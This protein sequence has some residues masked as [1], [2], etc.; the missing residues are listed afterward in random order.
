M[1]QRKIIKLATNTLVVSLPS[2]WAKQHGIK[3]GDAVEITE[4]PHKLTIATQQSAQKKSTL[5]LGAPSL[6]GRQINIAYKHGYDEIEVQYEDPKSYSAMAEELQNLIGFEVVSSG[7]N[8]C[9][10]KNIASGEIENFDTVLRRTFL[11]VLDM[12]E[13]AEQHAK[14]HTITAAEHLELCEKNID[15]LTD[16]CKRTEALKQQEQH[17]STAC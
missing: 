2:Q 9:T 16:F 10:V 5:S 13:A 3:K 17:C 8:H 4:Y 1:M 12:A 14:E 6:A 15:K 7:K 11:T